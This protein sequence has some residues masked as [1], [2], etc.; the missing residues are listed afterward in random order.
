[1]IIRM[2]IHRFR[3]KGGTYERFPRGYRHFYRNLRDF[4][5]ILGVFLP[6]KGVDTELSD[7]LL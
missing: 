1:M 5:G 3:Q 4:R 2:I 7:Y 6:Q